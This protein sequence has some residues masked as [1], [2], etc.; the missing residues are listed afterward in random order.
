MYIYYRLSLSLSLS[1]ESYSKPSLPAW[2]LLNPAYSQCSA[3]S[4]WD[5][6]PIGYMHG[7]GRLDSSRAWLPAQC[8]N[9]V[10]QWW[11]IE[12]GSILA[13]AGVRT[14][15]RKDNN[16]RVTS[17]KVY[18][19]T[20]GSSWWWVDNGQVFT[21]NSDSST[22]VNNLFAAPVSAG[23]IRIYPQS[24]NAYMSMRSALLIGN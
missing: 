24:W 17:F 7:L 18:A 11:Q 21:G 13:V 15:G 6:N 16:Q 20:D 19:S 2:N 14:Q 8:C 5:N 22:Y 1:H 12:V 3:S 9:S 10:G 4:V 23:Y